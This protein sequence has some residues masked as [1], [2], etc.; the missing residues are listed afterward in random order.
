[1]DLHPPLSAISG[2]L[3]VPGPL[4]L[5]GTAINALLIVTVCIAVAAWVLMLLALFYGL[6]RKNYEVAG[7]MF[8]LF[9]FA[10]TIC[11]LLFIIKPVGEY[12]INYFVCPTALHCHGY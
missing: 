1:M 12:L 4:F 6:V 2:A 7:R 11:I 10:F 8:A 3:T 9:A 5:F